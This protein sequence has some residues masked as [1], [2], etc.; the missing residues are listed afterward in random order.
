MNGPQRVARRRYQSARATYAERDLFLMFSDSMTEVFNEK[1]EE[2]RLTGLQQVLAKHAAGSLPE[3]C[4]LIMGE[5][6]RHGP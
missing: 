5:V 3:L 4:G 1:Y 6:R 2:F